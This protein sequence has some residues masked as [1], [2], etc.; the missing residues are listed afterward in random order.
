MNFGYCT[1]A[2]VK[3]FLMQLT[4]TMR[5]KH[6]A[7]RLK[8]MIMLQRQLS[9]VNCQLS[10]YQLS[11][12]NLSAVNYQFINCQ[13]PIYQQPIINLSTV[14]YYSVSKVRQSHCQQRPVEEMLSLSCGECTPYIC[15]PMLTISRYGYFSKNRPHSNPAWIA[16]TFGSALNKST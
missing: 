16:S 10:I 3:L 8:V 15:G 4:G 14:N 11:I 12:I 2:P 1:Y 13:L 6:P 5:R 7:H 9:I